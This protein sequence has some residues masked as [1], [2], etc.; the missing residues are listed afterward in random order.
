[1]STH[2]RAQLFAKGADSTLALLAYAAAAIALMVLDRR[3]G[4]LND[5]R[6]TAQAI[7]GPVWAMAEMPAK[8]A[9][10]SNVY[11]DDRS[12]LEAKLKALELDRLKQNTEILTLRAQVAQA[13]QLRALVGDVDL[14]SAGAQVARV[15]SV[16]LEHYSQRLV[17]SLGARQGV[18]VNAVLIDER[19]LLG[20]VTDVGPDSAIAMLIS[21]ERHR[22]PAEVVR[23]GLRVYVVGL[24]ASGTLALDRIALTADIQVGDVLQTSGMGGV[25]PGG[26]PIGEITAVMRPAGESF[27]QADVRASAKMALNKVVLVLPPKPE[28]GPMPEP[29]SGAKRARAPAG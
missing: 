28:M 16:D 3:L 24:G 26:I 14:A 19:G 22:V 6:A 21:D 17:I 23:N 5:V 4:Y 18:V 9:H 27:A 15:L 1:M 25:F 11:L 2:D 8:L 7:A 12:L 20:Q 29:V 10:A 13:A